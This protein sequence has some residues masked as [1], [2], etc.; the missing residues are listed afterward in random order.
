MENASNGK[1]SIQPHRDLRLS[2][3][4]GGHYRHKERILI[5]RLNLNYFPV[6]VA[7]FSPQQQRPKAPTG[8]VA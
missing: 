6:Q 2:N 7:F 3:T 8:A 1:G 4:D 5:L